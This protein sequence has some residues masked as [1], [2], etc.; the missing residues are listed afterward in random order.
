MQDIHDPTAW[1]SLLLG[2]AAL[3]AGL[4][5][6]RQPGLW[7]TM[8]VGVESSPSLQFLCGMLELLVGTLVYLANP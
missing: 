7:Q 6:L 8:I 2:L 1:A 4:G 3:A 5:A